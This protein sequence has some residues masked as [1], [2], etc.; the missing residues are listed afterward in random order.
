MTPG[1]VQVSA[2]KRAEREDALVLRLVNPT[3]RPVT[4][5][6]ILATP[7]REATIVNLAEERSHGEE[8]A[9]LARILTTGVRTHLR[10]GEIQTLLFR[11]HPAG[12]QAQL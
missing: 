5:E 10:G 4:T 12:E 3:H 7:F 8:S 9:K 11:L 1:N 2:V 6:V